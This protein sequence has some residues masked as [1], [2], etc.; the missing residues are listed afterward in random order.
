MIELGQSAKPKVIA[1]SADVEDAAEEAE[2]HSFSDSQWC[3]VALQR[4]LSDTSE[5]LGA[6]TVSLEA[7]EVLE[8]QLELVYRELACLEVLGRLNGEQLASLS[9][10]GTAIDEIRNIISDTN[11]P[12][13]SAYASAIEYRGSVGRPGYD[14]PQDQLEYLLHSKFTV[15]QIAVLL[16]VS[17]RTVRRRMEA[18]NLSVRSLYTTI[19]DL[20][21]DAVVRTIQEQFGL[22]GNRQMQGHL[23][24]QG[25]RVQ[26]LRVRECQRRVDPGGVALRRLT[27]IGRR[28]YRVNGPLALWHI[29][30][31]HKLIRYY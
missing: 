28:H 12:V 17:V 30:G 20:D 5:L 24:A 16:N 23:L 13:L 29:D 2:S 25:I 15:P 26:Q 7:L 1:M 21:L 3:R 4:I 6:E 22:C 19:S 14:I 27:S 11:Q 8:N 9:C 31:N 18:Y 10:T